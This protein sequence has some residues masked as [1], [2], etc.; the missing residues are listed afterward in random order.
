VLSGYRDLE[1]NK[2][3]IICM[4]KMQKGI[5]LKEERDSGILSKCSLHFHS[6]SA[7]TLLDS[8]EIP[9]VGVSCFPWLAP[10]QSMISWIYIH[11]SPVFL[12]NHL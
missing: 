8:I 1:A 3:K 6:F 12:A 4:K 2:N 7:L 5:G 10:F 9:Q 11:E